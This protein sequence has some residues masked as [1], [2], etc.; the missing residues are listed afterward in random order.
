MKFSSKIGLF[1]N[2]SEG[3]TPVTCEEEEDSSTTISDADDIETDK[4][5]AARDSFPTID[6]SND[7]FPFLNAL[8]INKSYQINTLLQEL[9]KLKSEK[10][11]IEYQ[12]GNNHSG[13]LL[14][15][16]SV[17]HTN[18]YGVAFARQ[19]SFTDA[20]VNVVKKSAQ[21][22]ESEGAECLLEA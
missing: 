7:D 11:V 21:C 8:G 10:R 2:D 20:A 9:V 3:I 22:T 6:L 5:T 12:K 17:R 18:R 16:P 19:G 4:K 1:Y 14:E 13:Y 15:V